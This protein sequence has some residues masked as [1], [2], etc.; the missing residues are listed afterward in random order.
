[1]KLL[2]LL[3]ILAVYAAHQ[4]IWN[5]SKSDPLVFGFLPIGLAYQAGYSIVASALMAVLVAFAW[6]KHL[7]EQD[8]PA[9]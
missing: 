9:K 7:E 6:P 5:W 4:D 1:K 2:L 8:P 3:L